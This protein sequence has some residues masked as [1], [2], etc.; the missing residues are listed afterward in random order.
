MTIPFKSIPSDIRVPLFYAEVDNSQANTASPAQRALLIGQMLSPGTAVAGVPVLCTGVANAAG[1]FGINSVLTSMVAT[2]RANDTFGEVWCLP[3][4][5]DAGAAAA[6]GSIAFT[7]A[8]TGSGTLSVY[9]AGTRYLVP[10]TPTKTTAQLATSLAAMINADAAAPVT[11][12]VSTNTVTLTADN[13]GPTGNDIDIRVNHLGLLGGEV[14][15]DGLTFT[16][17]AMSGGT[18]APS[19][20]AGLASLGTQTF[21]FI[22]SPYT[23]T[24]S[25]DALKTLLNDT[26]GRWAYS[27]QLYGHVFAAKRGTVGTLQ[28]AGAARNNQ[29]ETILGYYDSPTPSWAWACA[30]AGQCAASLRADPGMPLQTLAL[31]GVLSPPLASRFVM[32]DRQTLLTTGISTHTTGDDGTVRLERVI[33]TYQK[34]AFGAADNSYLDVETMFV[35]AYVLRFMMGAITSKFARVKLADDGTRFAA[36]SAIV[37]PAIIKAELIAQ[38]RELESRGLVQKG[39]DFAKGVIVQKNT[40]SPGR[41][42]VLWPGTL[43]EQL[44]IFALLAQFRLN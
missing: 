23:D 20:T 29:H 28:T 24:T 44:R 19:L 33:T 6:T 43:I 8:A 32:S 16:I 14:T 18:T 9:V 21:D 27:Q 12:S 10:V 30:M 40:A 38:Y 26:T 42:D 1:Q 4:A 31:N 3:L 11:A 37:T 5:D 39:A 13:K 36:G 15:P 25:L 34:N 17:T 7:A 41:V 22:V 35:L 2:Y